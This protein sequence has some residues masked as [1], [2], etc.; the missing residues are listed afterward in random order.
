MGVLVRGAG[1]IGVSQWGILVS[2][3]LV[4]EPNLTKRLRVLQKVLQF[5]RL[6][7]SKRSHLYVG[8]QIRLVVL[9]N[10]SS[11]IIG[12]AVIVCNRR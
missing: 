9:S 4:Q 10:E 7:S 11:K 1:S 12:R 2:I 5:L 6:R 3:F 8:P